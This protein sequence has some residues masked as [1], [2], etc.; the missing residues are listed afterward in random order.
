MDE[1]LNNWL[2]STSKGRETFLFCLQHTP[3][4]SLPGESFS[5]TRF[6]MWRAETYFV[7]CSIFTF[8]SHNLPVQFRTPKGIFRVRMF[9]VRLDSMWE[10]LKSLLLGLP[11]LP[12]TA[13][14]IQSYFHTPKGILRWRFQY[15]NDSIPYMKDFERSCLGFDFHISRSKPFIHTCT[16]SRGMIQEW[17]SIY[18][19]ILYVKNLHPTYAVFEC[20]L[21]FSV[22]FST[23]VNESPGWGFL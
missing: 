1:D 11:F 19:S 9:N 15:T 6:L 2:H 17:D 10:R 13:L 18:D 14:T 16:H 8:H 7:Q 3:Q 12:F 5:A 20:H 21:S 23:H 4:N 22:A